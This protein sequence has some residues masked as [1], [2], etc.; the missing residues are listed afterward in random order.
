MGQRAVTD[1]DSD[2]HQPADRQQ[3]RPR[4][5]VGTR[6]RRVDGHRLG[7]ARKPTARSPA[8]A[9][10]WVAGAPYDI[11]VTPNNAPDAPTLVAPAIDATDVETPPLLEVGVND[12]DGGQLTTTFYGR[13]VGAPAPEEFTIVVMPDTQHYVDVD[14]ARAAYYTEQT[15]WIAQH[16]LAAAARSEHRV[17]EPPRRHHRALRHRRDRVATRRRGD[18]HPRQRRDSRTRSRRATTT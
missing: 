6:R 3:L 15:Q 9:A 18:G 14:E 16:G 17:C 10:A 2:E 8:P 5:A 12:T 7:R 11:V 4:R 13:E 1:G